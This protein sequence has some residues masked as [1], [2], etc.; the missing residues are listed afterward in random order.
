[1]FQKELQ[2]IQPQYAAMKA[3]TKATL[4]QTERRRIPQNPSRLQEWTIPHSKWTNDTEKVRMNINCVQDAPGTTTICTHAQLEHVMMTQFS[5]RKGLE[6]A[7]ADAVISEM[8]QLH[9]REVIKPKAA[10]M[11]TT[12]C[13]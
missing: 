13:S 8:Q 2:T 9:K 7:S 4:D 11:L 1:V 10:H 6:E 3:T 5:I 12:S